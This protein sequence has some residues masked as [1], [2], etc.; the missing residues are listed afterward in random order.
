MTCTGVQQTQTDTAYDTVGSQPNKVTQYKAAGVVDSIMHVVFD[1]R[2]RVIQQSVPSTSTSMPAAKTVTAYTPALVG[3]VTQVSVTDPIGHVVTSVIDTKRGVPTSISDVQIGGTNVT[4]VAYDGV[5]RR[6]AV[7]LAGSTSWTQPNWKFGY[8]IPQPQAAGGYAL[9]STTEQLQNATPVAYSFTRTF[10]DGLGRSRETQQRSPSVNHAIVGYSRYDDRGMVNRDVAA[11]PYSVGAD[12][13]VATAAPISSGTVPAG[14]SGW[15]VV[16][17]V[18]TYDAIGRPVRSETFSN[19]TLK[20]TTTAADVGRHHYEYPQIGASSLTRTDAY[21]RQDLSRLTETGCCTGDLAVVHRNNDRMVMFGVGVEGDLWRKEQL[22]ARGAFGDW[23]RMSTGKVYSRVA[24]TVRPDGRLA[25]IAAD[26][27]GYFDGY[28]EGTV[29]T[30]N[31]TGP[32]YGSGLLPRDIA[33]TVTQSGLLRAFGLDANGLTH[34]YTQAAGGG[35][36]AWGGVVSN[37]GTG[38]T[39]IAATRFNDGRT[40]VAVRTGGGAV[41]V[42]RQ[43]VA[44]DSQPY[45]NFVN[46]PTGWVSDIDLDLN[47]ASGNLFLVGLG[48]GGQPFSRWEGT[49]DNWSAWAAMGVGGAVNVATER[50]NDGTLY[51]AIGFTAAAWVSGNPQGTVSVNT[52]NGPG[53]AF[54]TNWY[55]VTLDRDTYTT[56]DTRGGVTAVTDVGGNVTTNTYDW[57]GRTLSN[58]DPDKSGSAGSLTSYTYS[59]SLTGLSEVSVTDPAGVTIRTQSDVL[60]RPTSR[61][62]MTGASVSGTLAAWG[63]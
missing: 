40:A 34:F 6:T 5:G 13:A 48:G 3:L 4:Q 21:G 1:A 10:L 57:L 42:A 25:V 27:P 56:Y 11:F 17:T 26:V 7:L 60:G 36:Y 22:W 30:N 53:A 47:T 39:H 32:V 37:A 28:T 43:T 44:G 29:N 35:G 38:Q 23:V 33:L 46:A 16:S 49:P 12:P 14:A 2:G 15:P 58:H 62:V 45:T 18:K 24:A 31:W 55:Q 51:T 50:Y 63:V 20:S 61:D 9:Y 59:G 8:S 52:Q 54:N 19:S 41:W